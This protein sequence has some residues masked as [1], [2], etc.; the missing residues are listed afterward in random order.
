M[1]SRELRLGP[2]ERRVMQALWDHAREASVRE[3]HF[4]FPELAYTTL[5]TTLERLTRKAWLERRKLGR[6]FFY[7][8]RFSRSELTQQ[9][10]TAALG[11]LLAAG[12]DGQAIRPVLSFLVEAVGQRDRLLLDE[13][14]R[15]VRERR[16]ARPGGEA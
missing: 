5:M 6:A 7:R 3:L 1:S 2:L 14:E 12:G 15:L 4:A 8:P 16:K 11:E 9:N 10:A 13:L